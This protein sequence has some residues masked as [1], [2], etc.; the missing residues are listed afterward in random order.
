MQMTFSEEIHAMAK[1]YAEGS[2][3][4]GS[5]KRECT[6]LIGAVMATQKVRVL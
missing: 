5:K 6:A 2:G 1:A 3:A 4:H